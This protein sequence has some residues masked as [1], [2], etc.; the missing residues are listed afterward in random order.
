MRNWHDLLPDDL[1]V[2][3][4]AW[5]RRRKII[6]MLSFFPKKDVSYM[7]KMPLSKISDMVRRYK[8][9]PIT[10]LEDYLMMGKISATIRHPI[11]GDDKI[12]MLS[13]LQQ[14]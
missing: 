10:P 2:N 6:R 5:E 14:L 1:V 11:M 9:N 7:L 8:R 12:K 13:I 3:Q 4:I